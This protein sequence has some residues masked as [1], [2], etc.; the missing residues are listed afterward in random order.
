[1]PEEWCRCLELLMKEAQSWMF[2]LTC[3]SRLQ[4]S[5]GTSEELRKD[6]C[7]VQYQRCKLEKLCAVNVGQSNKHRLKVTHDKEAPHA[8]Q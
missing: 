7:P 4:Q 2:A 1:M 8:K 6:M 3:W 5:K